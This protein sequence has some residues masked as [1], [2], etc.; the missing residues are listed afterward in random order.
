MKRIHIIAMVF[1]AGLICGCAV[2]AHADAP[3]E[4]QPA[5]INLVQTVYAYHN[6]YL[7]ESDK[8]SEAYAGDS[9]AYFGNHVKDLKQIKQMVKQD[10]ETFADSYGAEMANQFASVGDN[11][12]IAFQMGDANKQVALAMCNY[13]KW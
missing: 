5:L 10:C 7:R 13:Y 2:P 3:K 11:P 1:I 6:Q 4:L 9:V 8:V 12:K